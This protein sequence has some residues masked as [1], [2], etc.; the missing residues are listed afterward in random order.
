MASANRYSDFVVSWPGQEVGKEVGDAIVVELQ[1]N[2]TDE[3]R[4]ILLKELPEFLALFISKN[5]EYGENAQTLGARGQFADIW[6]KIA[7]LKTGLWDGNEDR[8]KSEGVDEILRDL[9]GH[10]FLTLRIR[11][12]ER[13]A[14]TTDQHELWYGRSLITE[15]IGDDKP[16]P[17]R[18]FAEA[19]AEAGE[20]EPEDDF[21]L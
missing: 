15:R 13:D 18:R 21:G 11:Q 16:Q 2:E 20:D 3:L 4:D 1:G 14:E 9:I 7:K 19:M 17:R 5:Q 8:L 6:R 12:A 10:C